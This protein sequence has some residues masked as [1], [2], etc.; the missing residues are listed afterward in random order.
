MKVLLNAGV[1][2]LVECNLAKV[3][4][5]SSNLVSRSIFS[6]FFPPVCAVSQ[7]KPPRVLFMF[8]KLLLASC[9]A[10]AAFGQ[11]KVSSIGTPGSDVPGFF[12]SELGPGFQVTDAA[13]K[14]YCEIW[15]RRVVPSG[16]KVAEDSVTLPSVPQGSFIGVVRFDGDGY[17]RRGQKVKAGVYSLR[18]A[19]MPV[20]GDHLGAAPQRDFALMI[21]VA[22]DSDPK[23]VLSAKETIE[24]SRKASGTPHPAVLSMGSA[25]G[26]EGFAKDGDHDW[27]LTTKLGDQAVSMILVGKAE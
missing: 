3:D 18:Y 23:V 5:A 9:L 26:A 1:T 6:S 11:F 21:P 12:T 17:D 16:D 8:Y 2:Q 24:K 25:L 15:F 20:S 14:A 7:S 10:T 22:E 19:W 4:V 27:V 13:G